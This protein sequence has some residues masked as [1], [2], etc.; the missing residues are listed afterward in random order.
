MM[1]YRKD[2]LQELNLEVPETWDDMKV[3]LSVL[4]KNQMEIGM[5]ATEQIFATLLYQNGGQYY[6]ED[7]TASALDETVA[8]NVFKEYC[9][10]YSKYKLDRETSVEQRFRT[11]ETPIILADY[12]TYNNLQV[13]AP[14]IKGLWGFTTVPGTVKED[15]TI[16][17]TT[18]SSGNAAVIMKA[19]KNPEAAWEFLKWWTSADIQTAYGR[20]MESLM[21]ASARYPTANIEAFENLPWP[22]SD[23]EKL[24]E[25][26]EWVVGIPQVPGGYYTWRNVNNAFYQVVTDSQSPRETL[27]DYVRYINAEITNKR[28]ELGLSTYQANQEDDG[29]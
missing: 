24:K 3:A 20:E 4:S 16:D 19:C 18:V 28:E 13:S 21:G 9:E 12:T 22:R 11:G 25:Q 6:N 29:T 5:L 26:F 15:G 8:M 10:Y 7:G 2:I 14:D 27:T 23:Y 1:F 17:K